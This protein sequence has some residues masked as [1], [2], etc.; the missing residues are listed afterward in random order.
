MV[1]TGDQLMERRSLQV[2]KMMLYGTIWLVVGGWWW[3]W[4]VWCGFSTYYH[5]PYSSLLSLYIAKRAKAS[6]TAFADM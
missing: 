1:F 4:Y 2:E 3:Y 5:I 6:W